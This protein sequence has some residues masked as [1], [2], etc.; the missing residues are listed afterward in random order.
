[1][2]IAARFVFLLL[3]DRRFFPF[4]VFGGAHWLHCWTRTS[5]FHFG[6]YIAYILVCNL[7]TDIIQMTMDSFLQ[8]FLC[9]C[10]R[11]LLGSFIF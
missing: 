1:M 9:F 2:L 10:P 5:Y 6:S 4:L 11:C 8:R 7:A 3:F